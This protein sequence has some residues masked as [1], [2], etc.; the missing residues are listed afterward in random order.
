[1]PNSVPE[2]SSQAKM[3]KHRHAELL[4]FESGG[5]D[6]FFQ[7]ITGLAYVSSNPL[8]GTHFHHS[9]LK[10]GVSNELYENAEV[11]KAV[12]TGARRQ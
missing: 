1:M 4:H 12:A 10:C 3:Q 5:N 8:G 6:D 2:Y 9:P 11:S 7:P